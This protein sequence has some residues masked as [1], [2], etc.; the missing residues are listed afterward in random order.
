MKSGGQRIV[1]VGGGLGGLAAAALLARAGHRVTLIEAADY[2]G[3]KSRRIEVAGQ[4]VDTGP[5]LFTF[6]G[7]WRE[8]AR[9]CG[10]SGDELR[11][12]RMPEVGRY[13][14]RGE[15]VSLPV[16]EG[17]PWRA[18]WERFEREHGELGAGITALLTKDPLDRSALPDLARL[19]RTYGARLTTRSYL[20]SLGWMPEGL[21]EVIAIHTLNAGVSPA[22]T[23]ALYASMPAVMARDGVHVP[24]GGIYETVLAL[25]RLARDAGVEVRT[26]E[27]ATKV[28]EGAVLT[29]N[30]RYRCDLV[31]GAV[32]ED[33]LEA[34]T[35]RERKRPQARL[36]CSGVALY[37]ALDRSLDLPPHSVVLPESPEA[38]Y[39]DLEAGREPET[40]MAFVNYYAP[41]EVYPNRRPTLAVLLTAPPNGRAYAPSDA[42]VER[43]VARV[44][45]AVGLSRPA[46]E[47]FAGETVLHPSYFEERGG[48]GGALYGRSRAFWRS[49][50]LHRPRYNDRR[51]PW[52][53][54]VGAS[55]HPGGG[56]PA[57]LG[58]AMISTARLL[59]GLGR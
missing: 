6:P 5:S 57:V 37:A 50:P 24:E 22:R 12:R 36:S 1:V 45:E 28:A 17:H 54:R 51:R 31:V 4:R 55:V 15:S 49:G 19:L 14:F 13:H 21:K 26:G 3:G 44:S 39:R 16:E 59:R 56:I 33:R 42:F 9:R 29:A 11:L 53:W 7:V 10:A 25:E 2:L 41:G 58:G 18:A 30:S 27:A 38:L 47:Y 35:E 40:T 43:E 46:T 20:D 52:L 48:S 32:D 23:P 8:L 34:L